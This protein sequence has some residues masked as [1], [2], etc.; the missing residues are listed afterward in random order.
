MA[1][2]FNHD[3]NGNVN[4]AGAVIND[5][6][7]YG[8][9]NGV[10]V[11]L[12]TVN[13]GQS[14]PQGP[15]VNQNGTAATG[16]GT[17]NNSSFDDLLAIWDT[18]NGTG[19]TT[20]I[21]GTPVGWTN[22]SY[23]ASTPQ[24]GG[25]ALV[26][27]GVGS[28]ISSVDTNS[29]YVALE[30]VKLN[31]APVLDAAPSP[32]LTSVYANTT[33]TGAVGDL[34][35]SLTT[36]ISD[37][38][39]G[40]TKG[41]AI[42][43]G[44][45]GGTVW[46][47]LNGGTTWLSVVAS[48]LSDTNALL[49]A[50]DSD[51][52]V[53]FQSAAGATTVSNALTFRAWDMTQHITEGV[54]VSTAATGGKSE[55]STAT[56]T[57]SF[58]A[59]PA[60][61]AVELSAINGG[62][63]GFVI[64]GES[65]SDY[66]GY[67][68]SNAGDVNGDG[69]A[70][71][72]V[73][74]FGANANGSYSGKTYVVYGKTSTT[75][76]N[77]SA[78]AAG[79]GGFVINGQAASDYSGISVSSAGDINGD[80]LA[81]LII[82]AYQANANGSHSGRTYVVF[83]T[84]S[85]STIN[86][87]AVA[88]GSGGFVINGQAASDTSGN[89][90]SSVGD[91][92]GDGLADLI[93]G[94]SGATSYTGKSYIVFGTTSNAAINLSAIAAGSGG[95][96]INGQSAND[97]SG[98]SV[99]N[100]GDINGD[101]LADLI[102]G[103]AGAGASSTGK[104]YVVF[105]TTSTSAINLS[106]VANGIG[107]FVVNGESAV[108]Y[109]GWSVSNAG[110]VNGDGFADLIVGAKA[111]GNTIGKSYIVFGSTSTT[112]INLSAVAA[113][114]GG[115]VI[116]GLPFVVTGQ[117]NSDE[118][119]WSVSSAGDIN[120]DGLADLIVGA[121]Y[122]DPT[123]GMD[124]GKTYIVFGTTSTGAINLSAVANGIGGFVINGQ[125]TGNFSGYSVSNA[126]DINGD[127]F[128]DLIVGA[129]AATNYAGKTYVIFGG[130]QF[131]PVA[132]PV[133][134]VGTTGAD[135]QTGT[136]AAETFMAGAGADTLIGNGGADVMNGGAGNDTFV[137]NASNITALSS[138]FGTGGNTAQLARIDG[139]TGFDTVRLIGGANLDLT[140]VS[141]V[142]GMNPDGTSRIESIERIDLS[143]DTAAN[144][145]TITARD[146]NDMAGMNLIHSGVSA[147]GN[148]W[149][150]GTYTLGATVAMHQLV[151]DG[152]AADSIVFAADNGAWSS[153]GT[154][155][156]S[157]T[158]T[159]Y[160]VY[161]NTFTNSQVLIKSSV[162]VTNNDATV[163]AVDLSAIVG[164]TGGFVINGQAASD[165][166]G[167]SVSNAGDINGDGLADVIISA[168]QATANAAMYAGK[169]YVVFGKTNSTAIN[170][171]AIE[172]GNGG[173]VING[174]AAS[175]DSGVS[176]SSAGDINGDGLADIIVGAFYADPIGGSAAGKS[177]VVYGKT[178]TTAVNL[179]AVAASTGGFMINGEA[180]NDQSG[181]SVSSAG[182][183]NGDGLADVIIGAYQATAASSAAGKSYVVFGTTSSAT[184]NLS[185]IA[186]GNGGFVI[187]GQSSVDYSG[188]SVSSAGDVN[189]DGLADLIVGA[190][191]ADPTG[192]TDAG[193]SYVVYG[194]TSTTAIDLSAVAG[195]TGG[196]VINGQSA[197]DW[198]GLSVSSAG[199]ING[200]GLADVIV[201]AM[202]AGPTAGGNAGKTYVVY[203]TTS[204]AAINLS[205]IEGGIGGF[206]INGQSANDNSG[207]S[208]SN[209][210]DV[211]GD[212]LAD[213]LVGAYNAT[214][215]GITAA[216]KTYVVYGTTT[217]AAINLSNI[218]AGVGGFVIN[219]QATNDQNGYSV[220]AAGDINGDG[221]ADLI[222][223]VYAANSNGALSG[224]TYVIY[225]G[226]QYTSGNV[227][228]LGTTGADT[229]TGTAAAETFMAGA[230]ADTLI[231][232]G[233]A[234]VMNAGAGNDTIIIN[235]SNI[236]ALS[237]AF[238][239][240]GNTTQL[241]RIDGGTGFDTV[242][243]TGGASLDLTTVSNVGGMNPDGTSRIESIERID[244][245]TDTA[246]NTL[247]ISAR[248][249]NDMAGFNTI[250][251][252]TASADGNTWTNVSGTALSATTQYHQVVVDGTSSDGV[253]LAAGDGYWANAGTVNN[254]SSDYTV[255]QNDVTH[256]QVLVKSDVG[257]TNND[258][259]P[260]S[261][262]G[263]A[264][265]DLGSYGKLIDPVKVEGKWYYYWDL[266]GDGIVNSVGSGSL[267]GGID[268]VNHDALDLIFTQDING[269]T[270]GGGNTTEVYRYATLNGV[271][272]A[273]P[274]A[275][276]GV[277]PPGGI[278]ANNNGTAYEDTT[279]GGA[280]D[281]NTSS[282]NELLAIWDA[283]NG[284]GT[285][286]DPAINAW[287]NTTAPNAY[288]NASVLW[289][290][291]PTSSGHAS[292]WFS[293]G[294]VFDEVDN[295]DGYNVVLQV[296]PIVLDLNHDGVLSYGTV[297]MDVN[298]D[299]LL[300]TT[301]WA[302]S[303]DGTLIWDKYQDGII[304][305]NTQYAFAQYDKDSTNGATDLSGLADKFDTNHDGVFNAADAQFNEFKIWQDVNQNGIS[306]AGEV[307]TLSEWGI[308]SIN[309]TSDGVVRT[310]TQGV[311]EAGQTT[312]TSTDG[313]TMLVADAAFEYSSIDYTIANEK[314]SFLGDNLNLDLANIATT[315]AHI[316]E[317]DMKDTGS[318]SLKLTLADVLHVTE[319]GN[320]FISGDSSDSVNID[321]KNS[322]VETQETLTQNAHMYG[323]YHAA[324]NA[325]VNLYID[326]AIIS[327]NHVI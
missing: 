188:K 123:G 58:T 317:I 306:D 219:G 326:T 137:I 117:C 273:L 193:K 258:A 135:T 320:L 212:G 175:D 265:I 24:S 295:A 143:T 152:T 245:S 198:S 268:T 13:G 275:N 220:S 309:L 324:E 94:A 318:N 231:G 310:P 122:A 68:V 241:A 46:Y 294:S 173:F 163:S 157:T 304:H 226:T 269:V 4:P 65:T 236:T 60:L 43:G 99:S 225:G 114:S 28:E 283:F 251:T 81:D 174:Q 76:I 34:V 160:N 170:L 9:I 314:F 101:G 63:G 17:T 26:H 86:L 125:T 88:A 85:T 167:Y 53:Y 177:Y 120:G 300:D 172:A 192:G 254:G 50:A 150:S 124:A 67:S 154:V 250:H 127:G 142:G 315:G 238:G 301:K 248:D 131:V 228:F 107:G 164:G 288:S 55:F 61:N 153:V 229:Q 77:L 205:A 158:G 57:V 25:H 287:S 240:G 187:K 264:V 37:A 307:G 197:N 217:T 116:N 5:T 3:I 246:A 266:S 6:Y 286:S 284:T 47:S 270:G 21:D 305:D 15:G 29:N 292:V 12:P 89:S 179:S 323:V 48:T 14:L 256:S 291:T 233:G 196:F 139:G 2:T 257:V 10:L 206:V 311:T 18:K 130:T 165:F 70:D 108:D 244:L 230:G 136:A 36:G 90:V 181:Y 95:F 325:S 322:W 166:S 33:P 223:G 168:Y 200:D 111:A 209:A 82:G 105:G 66:S 169:S 115:F 74:A 54:L 210:G 62:T 203:G 178:S 132:N 316:H 242:R 247:T 92:N 75:G 218:A 183:V 138:A 271:K 186:A 202:H 303:R 109:S 182:D 93:V 279:D 148:T 272:V 232:N 129:Y 96:V 215:N 296:L 274:T 280:S 110:D 149:S 133:D 255:Y 293:S 267:N 147:D 184:I 97:N 100:A 321:V 299:G 216:G 45:T 78:I 102:I 73:G 221:F 71:I 249:V 222:L 20:T 126:G 144:T 237:S 42:T 194:K 285:T 214:A 259:P 8:T 69:L 227:D 41:I 180:G 40:A 190:Y 145:L 64:N 298:G 239:S 30:V 171:S 44:G 155:T 261:L 106:A 281:A 51:T 27:L 297:T 235:A 38:D 87:S 19:T 224:K 252:S 199:D 195:G 23:W 151:V 260:V 204:N 290:A 113:G 189:G 103:A 207:F 289:S 79:S 146:V 83:G 118:S 253:T 278:N 52:R 308:E 84:T 134:F 140:T 282:Y 156:N 319:N 32:T 49:L 243:L 31:T 16:F 11:A 141:N 128:A 262:A 121:P 327:A 191:A 22:S 1:S 263:N 159:T 176:V 162:T 104:T 234:D 276:G 201:G 213:I 211:N 208:V 91:V 80:G 35:S 7:R 72:I 312:A 313:S 277:T 185:A 39:S 119:G 98:W 56:D 59:T 112:A 161:Q 302:G